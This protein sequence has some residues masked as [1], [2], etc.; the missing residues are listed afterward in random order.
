MRDIG[1]YRDKYQNKISHNEWVE[2]NTDVSY[3]L[4]GSADIGSYWVSTI[5][6]GD[7]IPDIFETVVLRI[8]AFTGAPTELVEGH[9]R[10]YKTLQEAEKG[11][12]DTC[13]AI[14]KL[15]DGYFPL[16]EVSNW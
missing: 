9:C 7:G 11:H 16:Q 5:W 14:T 10:K 12:Q 6:L 8:E 13:E 4:I 3:V 15:V 2:L 1:P